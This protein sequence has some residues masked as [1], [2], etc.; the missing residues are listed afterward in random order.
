MSGSVQP[1]SPYRRDTE[2]AED[3]RREESIL[4]SV[5]SVSTLCLC[6]ERIPT[7]QNLERGEVTLDRRT[8]ATCGPPVNGDAASL[9]VDGKGEGGVPR[10]TDRSVCSPLLRMQFVAWPA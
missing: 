4:L 7:S 5:L 8:I 6:D 10:S 2:N 9:P 1:G 3:T